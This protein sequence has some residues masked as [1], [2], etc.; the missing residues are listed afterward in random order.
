MDMALPSFARDTITVKRASV[1]D[2]RGTQIRD[3]DNPV[4]HTV[5]GCSV[6]FRETS[7]SYDAREAVTVRAVVYM[8]PDADIETGDMVVFDDVE[9]AIDGA[10]FLMRSPTGR[11]SHKKATLVDWRG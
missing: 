2:D 1:I 9:Y 3:W 5:T 8:P 4:E 7:T 6:Q 10:P 11:T